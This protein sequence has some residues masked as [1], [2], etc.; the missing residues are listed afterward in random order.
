[1]KDFLHILGLIGFGF[2]SYLMAAALGIAGGGAAS[3]GSKPGSLTVIFVGSFIVVSL[4]AAIANGLS[5][6]RPSENV[7]RISVVSN[8]A[9]LA[10]AVIF[11]I[12][13]AVNN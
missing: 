5:V 13:I 3:D 8:Y 10:M 9:G 7:K 12:L 2:V 1:M 6:F 11:A 4:C